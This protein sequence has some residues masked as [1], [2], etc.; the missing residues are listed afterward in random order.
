MQFTLVTLVGLL[1]DKQ[2]AQI[3]KKTTFTYN[4]KNLQNFTINK[5]AI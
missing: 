4:F 1:C 3:M 5:L 2:F